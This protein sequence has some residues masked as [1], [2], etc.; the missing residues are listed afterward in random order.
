MVSRKITGSFSWWKEDVA[1]G[2]KEQRRRILDE[3]L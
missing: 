2:R 1:R 3:P